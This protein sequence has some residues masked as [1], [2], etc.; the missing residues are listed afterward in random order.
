MSSELFKVM[1]AS[2]QHQQKLCAISKQTPT[3]CQP[4]PG[5]LRSY[6]I[7]WPALQ[8]AKKSKATITIFYK[9]LNH[10]K[11]LHDFV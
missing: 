3:P 1:G 4:A 9:K 8:H 10:R 7:V 6:L 11:N 5:V 2:Q